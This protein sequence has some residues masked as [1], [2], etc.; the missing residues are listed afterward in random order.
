MVSRPN[1]VAVILAGCRRFAKR[2]APLRMIGQF[3]LARGNA[4]CCPMD[5]SGPLMGS[6]V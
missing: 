6:N 4:V 3:C 1:I 5:R 2:A